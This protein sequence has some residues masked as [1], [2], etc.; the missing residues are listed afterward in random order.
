MLT[1]ALTSLIYFSLIEIKNQTTLSLSSV[2][3]Q[4]ISEN[5][6]I[7][8]KRMSMSMGKILSKIVLYECIFSQNKLELQ[9]SIRNE[10]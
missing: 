9:T 7:D 8:A 2:S 10:M 6:L 5:H 4:K 3:N 1:L